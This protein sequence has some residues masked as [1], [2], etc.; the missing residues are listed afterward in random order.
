VVNH[1]EFRSEQSREKPDGSECADRVAF[2]EEGKEGSW[3]VTYQELYSYVCFS[4][5][6]LKEDGFERGDTI[7]ILQ[8][9]SISLYVSLLAVFHAGLTAMFID[10]SVGRSM[11]RKSLKRHRPVGMIGTP[12][13]QFLR[14]FVPELW[15]LKK[16]YCSGTW[17]PL[18]CVWEM[19]LGE[20]IS[21]EVV[22]GEAPALITFTSGSTGFPKVACRT[23]AF[24]LAQ[25]EALSEALDYQEGEV[26]LVTLPIF[27]MANIAA[28]MTSIIANT[29]LRFPVLADSKAI[30]EQCKRYQVTRCAASPAFF[31]KLNKDGRMPNFH[32]IYTG[33]APVFP[34]SLNAIQQAWP[35]MKVVTVFG[36]TEAEPISHVEWRQVGEEDRL[37]MKEGLG[38]L[39]GV[40]VRQTEVRVIAD[41][42]GQSINELSDYELSE[43]CLSKGQR[44]EV[45]VSGDHVL[46]GYL[47]GGGDKESKFKVGDTV[48]HRTGDAAYFDEL[49]RL[50]LVGRCSAALNLPDGSKLY[51]FG[52]ECAGVQVEGVERCA[53]VMYQE[54]VTLLIQ[55]E[56][57]C[58][59]DVE[60]V[61]DV[62]KVMV[63]L[64]VQKVLVLT[65]I[66]VDRRHNAKVDYVQ[67]EKIVSSL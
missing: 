7:L 34:H 47:G 42:W 61:S 57:D 31:E 25:N 15:N 29:D 41:Q 67:L 66:P 36:S 52:I 37:K 65:E 13:A 18:S 58:F 63:S 5:K 44:G 27:A 50:W 39:V 23:H 64:P 17:F 38:L 9:V 32:A 28:G 10:P 19:K 6:R 30:F 16:S 54:K 20:R 43:I 56:S 26:D 1:L 3:S 55:L 53:L 48:W 62:E 49:D 21:P 8:P 45:I 33:G 11:I 2:V 51:P 22:T 24:L 59:E 14:C 40:P 35:N 12:K 46:D 4:S 60:I